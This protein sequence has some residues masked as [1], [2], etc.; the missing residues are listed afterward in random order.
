MTNHEFF[1]LNLSVGNQ[2][3]TARA[4]GKVKVFEEYDRE[5]YVVDGDSV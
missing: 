2:L 5:S 3:N 1:Q 4:I